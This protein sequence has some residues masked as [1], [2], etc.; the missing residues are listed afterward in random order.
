VST[1]IPLHSLRVAQTPGGLL[2][3]QDDLEV[4]KVEAGSQFVRGEYEEQT[5]QLFLHFND[6]TVVVEGFITEDDIKQ[7]EPGDPGASGRDGRDGFAARDGFRGQDGCDGARGPVGA[8]GCRGQTGAEGA[9][10]LIGPTGPQGLQGRKGPRGERGDTGL[11]NIHVGEDDP[12]ATGAGGLWVKESGGFAPTQAPATTVAPTDA[13]GPA[14]DECNEPNVDVYICVDNSSSMQTI[15]PT[16]YMSALIEQIVDHFATEYDDRQVR[17]LYTAGDSVQRTYATNAQEVKTWA[18]N[19]LYNASESNFFTTMENVMN[20]TLGYDVNYKYYHIYITNETSRSSAALADVLAKASTKHV[21]VGVIQFAEATTTTEADFEQI[22]SDTEGT[23]MIGTPE[24]CYD[25]RVEFVT[26]AVRCNTHTVIDA[27]ASETSDSSTTC[28]VPACASQLTSGILTDNATNPSMFAVADATWTS[29]GS[30]CQIDVMQMKEHLESL[31]HNISKVFFMDGSMTIDGTLTQPCDCYPG[32]VVIEDDTSVGTKAFFR[33][34]MVDMFCLPADGYAY[35][36]VRRWERE[37]IYVSVETDEWTCE[38]EREFAYN[39]VNIW[40]PQLVPNKN[41]R[42]T[43]DN[44]LADIRINAL[45]DAN[46]R[47]AIA[48]IIGSTPPIGLVGMVPALCGHPSPVNAPYD[49]SLDL[50]RDNRTS[51]CMVD[52]YLTVDCNIADASGGT[53]L[54]FNYTE[55]LQTLVHEFFHALGLWHLSGPY[56]QV[57]IM[58]EDYA[59]EATT[60]I[61]VTDLLALRV[62]YDGRITS[63]MTKAEVEHVIDTTDILDQ[64]LVG[65]LGI[66]SDTTNP[67]YNFETCTTNSEA[68]AEMLEKRDPIHV[69]NSYW[70]YM[71]GSVATDD[72]AMCCKVLAPLRYINGQ[73]DRVMATFAG[74]GTAASFVQSLYATKFGVHNGVIIG[75]YRD[76]NT[77]VESLIVYFNRNNGE[78]VDETSSESIE[79]TVENVPNTATITHRDTGDA[80]NVATTEVGNVIRLT[81]TW[82]PNR[83]TG[84][85]IENFSTTVDLTI[86]IRADFNDTVNWLQFYTP[87][88][89]KLVYPV[90]VPRDDGHTETYTINVEKDEEIPCYL[91]PDTHLSPKLVVRFRGTEYTVGVIDSE[92][93]PADLHTMANGCSTTFVDQQD[94]SITLAIQRDASADDLWFHIHAKSTSATALMNIYAEYISRD[95]RVDH[96]TSDGASTDVDYTVGVGSKVYVYKDMSSCSYSLTFRMGYATSTMRLQFGEL[97]NLSDLRFVADGGE[98]FSVADLATGDHLEIG[99]RTL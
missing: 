66:L 93:A 12:G 4:K 57:S 18:V 87:L 42:M 52:V 74:A 10:G 32:R 39:F 69:P 96:A 11:V 64:W 26:A 22:C 31:G 45:G 72:C 68:L 19:L 67:W 28:G 25:K 33:D 53:S 44:D 13:P 36:T 35:T 41:W 76:T 3:F 75:F 37:D 56:D 89:R 40:L 86:K 63:G 54:Q 15:D 6:R 97:L 34:A 70:L 21:Q 1:K 92:V 20:V 55:R 17:F 60:Y 50:V 24:A 43:T 99:Y 9:I 29:T 94:D 14:P 30:L 51:T 85:A 77:G 16:H 47:S 82:R 46:F 80:S 88:A 2:V 61:S 27:E 83:A 73:K 90:N 38:E 23:F 49:Y 8:S 98:A 91:S 59:P 62:L 71:V 84:A 7:G 79:V 5:G 58:D 65:D 48:A 81:G 78:A 95:C